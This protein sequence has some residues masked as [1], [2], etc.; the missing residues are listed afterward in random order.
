M[1]RNKIKNRVAQ[2]KRSR[3]TSVEA[4][5]IT[6]LVRVCLTFYMESC[7]IDICRFRTMTLSPLH[8]VVNWPVFYHL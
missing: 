5:D 6:L 3:Q 8:L 7:Q 1:E 4:W 2:K